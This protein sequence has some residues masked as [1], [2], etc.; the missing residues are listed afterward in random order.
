MNT[1][2]ALAGRALCSC[3]LLTLGACSAE[4]PPAQQ[5][6]PPAVVVQ[7]VSREAVPLSLT[8]AARTAGSREVEVRAR[9]SGIL[10]ERRY[11]E[12]AR[13]KAGQPMFLIDPAP[14][15]ARLARAEA[16][17]AMAQARLREARRT[18]D[19]IEAL[20]AEKLVSQSQRDEA[21]ALF[22]VAEATV[23]S[24]QAEVRNA[25][26]DLEY[27]DVRAPIAGLT[28][29]ERRSEGSL[30]AT[31]PASSLLTRI[32][33]IEPLYVEFSLPQNE[34]RLLRM[35]MGRQDALKLKLLLENG[36]EHGEM[37]RLDFLDNAIDPATGT[38]RARAVL[39]NKEGTLLPGQFLRA[40]IEGV[41]LGQAVTVPR[42]ALMPSPQGHFVWSVDGS[43][44]VSP[45]PVQIERS[46]GN[47]VLV[48]GLEPG[49]RY[50]LEGVLKVQPGVKVQP[51]EPQAA[52]AAASAPPAAGVAA[53]R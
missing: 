4:Q 25:K 52:P 29:S 2:R 40:R 38:V 26:I 15:Q 16:E 42:K 12:G 19:R 50:V 37:A 1:L 17:L 44:V 14:F 18:R 43:N 28:S 51:M 30:V 34:A 36:S 10:L 6:P 33:Q 8:Y 45:H 31:D 3:I 24:A 27:T 21:L 47:N 13:V 5:P 48:S 35:Q 11:Q 22:E 32:V 53:Q 41:Q 20:V 9:V 23:A 46:M 49:A 7:T 39:D